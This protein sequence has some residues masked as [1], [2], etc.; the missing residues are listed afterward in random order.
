VTERAF[1]FNHALYLQFGQLVIFFDG[2]RLECGL[3][4]GSGG[5]VLSTVKIE[6]N[7]ERLRLAALARQRKKRAK[8]RLLLGPIVHWRKR[9]QADSKKDYQSVS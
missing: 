1:Y 2:E 7:R 5:K 3:I 6:N 8:K 9:E 4:Q